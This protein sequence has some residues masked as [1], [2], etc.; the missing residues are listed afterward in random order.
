MIETSK[1]PMNIDEYIA[2]FPLEQQTRMQVI[3]KLIRETAPE[4]NER[5]AYQMPTFYYYGNL[6]HFACFTHHIGFFPGASGVEHFLPELEGYKTSKGTIQIPHDK[7]LPL[8]LIKRIVEFRLLENAQEGKL[9]KK[10]K[11]V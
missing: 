8:E 10:K 5:M 7:D 1:H 6:V 11:N 4:A 9:K 3:R 2:L